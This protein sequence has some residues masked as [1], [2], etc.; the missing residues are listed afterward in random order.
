MTE[1]MKFTW[2]SEH[3]LAVIFLR[4]V[5]LSYVKLHITLETLYILYMHMHQSQE[6]RKSMEVTWCHSAATEILAK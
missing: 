2:S 1:Y 6:Y 5:Y 4:A 3:D